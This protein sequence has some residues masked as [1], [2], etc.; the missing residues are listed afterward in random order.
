MIQAEQVD[1]ELICRLSGDW[2]ILHAGD[3]AATLARLPGRLHPGDRVRF[4]CAGLAQLDTAGAWLL[5][6]TVRMLRGSGHE[7]ALS[8]FRAAN[9]H[10]IDHLEEVCPD[11]GEH[12]VGVNIP[13][14]ARFEALGRA[15]VAG[16][17]HLGDAAAFLGRVFMT[18]GRCMRQ[19]RRIRVQAVVAAMYHAGVSALPIVTL[20]TFLIAVVTAYQGAAQLAQFGAE[21]FTVEFTVGSLLRELSA[22]LTAV[23][24]AGRSG[25]A[26]TAEIGVMKIREEIDAMQTMGLDPYEVLVLPRV[27][28][29][30]IM[31]PLMTLLANVAGMLGALLSAN[32]LL[33]MTV[34]A[35]FLNASQVITAQNFWAGM[36]KTPVFAFLIATTGCFWGL[37]VSGSADSVGRLTTISVVQSLFL[38]LAADAVF[39]V[40][41][42]Q[43]GI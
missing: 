19:P 12:T 21:V 1:G 11:D 40:I 25:S 37:R 36:M 13:L 39:A 26:F 3:I 24:V 43:L 2:T 41:H 15:T 6:K 18:S 22:L 9:F 10:L 35:Y 5:Q 14:L 30:M 29:L 34:E 23:V 31:L 27:L 20:M 42:V 7:V 32:L 28:A 38:I 33:D 8:G 17:L 4:E 16:I